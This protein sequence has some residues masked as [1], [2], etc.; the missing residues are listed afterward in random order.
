M[1]RFGEKQSKHLNGGSTEKRGLGTHLQNCASVLDPYPHALIPFPG[2]HESTLCTP[3]PRASA[4]SSAPA[5]TIWP[6]GVRAVSQRALH[7]P[8]H[9]AHPWHALLLG[10][11]PWVSQKEGKWVTN[12]E[13][14]IDRILVTGNIW[15]TPV[16]RM[17]LSKWPCLS[18]GRTL[19][20]LH[21]GP[22]EGQK[23]RHRLTTQ[24]KTFVW[25]RKSRLRLFNEEE[26]KKAANPM[27]SLCLAQLLNMV[28]TFSHPAATSGKPPS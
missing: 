8:S 22:S 15:T 3:P 7:P 6:R 20:L 17:P 18:R 25:G 13:N 5:Q 24:S 1:W 11:F 23:H 9:V 26:E 16:R 19:W 21:S 4:D 2:A 12:K 14:W 28:P 10:L 27:P